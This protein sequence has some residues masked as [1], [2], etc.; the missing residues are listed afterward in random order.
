MGRF[1]FSRKNVPLLSSERR[2]RYIDMTTLNK[3]PNFTQELCSSAMFGSV[4]RTCSATH[5]TILDPAKGCLFVKRR[6]V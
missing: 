4:P 3:V 1:A 6:S 5:N 2:Y